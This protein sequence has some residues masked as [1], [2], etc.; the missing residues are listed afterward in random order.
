MIKIVS[1]PFRYKSKEYYSLIRFFYKNDHTDLVV[2]VMNGEMEKI[3]IGNNVIQYKYGYLVI[4]VPMD[5]SE[6]SNIKMAIIESIESY[7]SDKDP[8]MLSGKV[9]SF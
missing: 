3:L 6:L 7:L 5:E 9:N 4:D 2:T 1:I 8:L